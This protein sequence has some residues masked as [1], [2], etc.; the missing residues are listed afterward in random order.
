MFASLKKKHSSSLM[1]FIC[2][3]YT[4]TLVVTVVKSIM[5][6]FTVHVNNYCLSLDTVFMNI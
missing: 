4:Y 6:R 3:T 2:V 5:C 1:T